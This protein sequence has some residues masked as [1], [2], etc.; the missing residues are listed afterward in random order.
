MLLSYYEILEK[1]NEMTT[2]CAQFPS[3]KQEEM[4]SVLR[5]LRAQKHREPR[6]YILLFVTYLPHGNKIQPYK[7]TVLED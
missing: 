7:I 1:T 6:R 2:R 5:W 3:T 4:R